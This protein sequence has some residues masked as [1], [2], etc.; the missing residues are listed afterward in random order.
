MNFLTTSLLARK[1]ADTNL[2]N[3]PTSN[4]SGNKP[5]NNNGFLSVG[6]AYRPANRAG[7][8]FTGPVQVPSGSA[9]SPSV[10][11]GSSQLGFYVAS[12]ELSASIN[13]VR[14][15]RLDEQSRVFQSASIS[16]FYVQADGLGYYSRSNSA[17]Y[18]LGES[19]DIGFFRGSVGP[20][21]D[22]RANGGLRSRNLANNADAPITASTAIFSGTVFLP[23]AGFIQ[24]ASTNG[25]ISLGSFGGTGL[26]VWAHAVRVNSGDL[27]FG[28]AED[29]QLKR[30]SAS[31][32]GVFQAGGTSL[33]NLQVDNIH[34][35]SNAFNLK[36]GATGNLGGWGGVEVHQNGTRLQEWGGFNISLYARPV[37]FRRSILNGGATMATIDC[38]T[39]AATFSGNLTVGNTLYVNNAQQ[40]VGI[41]VASG[42]ALT[43]GGDRILT[44]SGGSGFLDNVGQITS[45]GA[46][47]IASS[48]VRLGGDVSG[49]RLNVIGTA[50]TAIP[51]AI[52]QGSGG[53]SQL[54]TIRDSSGV[55][56]IAMH[57]TGA[58]T[59]SGNVQMGNGILFDSTRRI[60]GAGQIVYQ[61]N[62]TANQHLFANEIGTSLTSGAVVQIHAGGSGV[63]PGVNLLNLTNQ[64][65]TVVASISP[66]GAA[67]FSGSVAS[68]IIAAGSGGALGSYPLTVNGNLMVRYAGGTNLR[69]FIG[70][71]GDWMANSNEN[72]C[73]SAYTP[74]AHFFVDN[75]GSAGGQSLILGNTQNTLGRPTV[76]R[77]TLSQG[78]NS[79]TPSARFRMLASG[80]RVSE[81]GD[82][83]GTW[84]SGYREEYN[85]SGLRHGFYGVTPV[86]RQQITAATVTAAELLTA[87]NNL[88]LV[89]SI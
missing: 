51:V 20:T 4:P 54:V 37:L 28:N 80:Q 40:R 14:Q 8:T 16:S 11:V 6:A 85:A 66:T 22:V 2:G 71:T 76:V 58:A 53:A 67:T 29:V 87:L 88:G 30:I 36:L 50:D 73:F 1:F 79:V 18:R 84:Q 32:L 9:A 24:N 68:P 17:G 69:A 21:F 31:N 19:D 27:R 59:F 52:Q 47:M 7:D 12:N 57:S 60:F 13:G 83:S 62:A 33:G 42:S 23:D 74:E 48:N 10:A 45:S 3:L 81:V 82:G 34:T 38:E 44:F 89:Q 75:V 46:L 70:R 65:S 64:L 35:G 86:A 72:F 49:G 77:D 5:W 43:V 63:G 56:R 78:F 61:S 25:N 39:G 41:G 26:Q 55:E 15:W